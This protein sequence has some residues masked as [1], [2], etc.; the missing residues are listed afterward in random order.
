M[1]PRF[2]TFTLSVLVLVTMVCAVPMGFFYALVN[3][4]AQTIIHERAP[5]G[6]R[7]RYFGTQ[8]LLANCTS[9]LLLLVIGAGADALGVTA[10]L[11]L[12]APVV[13]AVAVAGLWIA[14]GA[15]D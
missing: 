15:G 4:P 7:G 5:A 1:Q 3:A 6:M 14:R 12:Y 13:L 2:A 8:M 11:L 9:L 10:M